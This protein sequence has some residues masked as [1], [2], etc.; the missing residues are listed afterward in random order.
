MAAQHKLRWI[1]S[2]ICLAM[3][4]LAGMNTAYGTSKSSPERII[5][6]V[7]QRYSYTPNEIVLK[8]GEPVLLQIKSL[9]F[10][11]GF[12]I[13]DLHIRSDLPPGR[14]TTINL[15]P[16]K[17]GTYDFLCDNFCGAGHEN[18]NGKI[19]VKD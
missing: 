9:D 2:T 11:H 17:S 4:A 18:M 14:V 15:T 1:I 3:A 10:V 5:Q 19:I 13:P 8:T 7:A 12:N 16:K 6:I